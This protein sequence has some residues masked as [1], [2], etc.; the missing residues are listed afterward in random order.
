[1]RE[2]DLEKLESHFNDQHKA[3]FRE[4]YEGVKKYIQYFVQENIKEYPDHKNLIVSSIN[5]N[6][7]EAFLSM[8]CIH[9]AMMPVSD[10][11]FVKAVKYVQEQL[12]L[13]ACKELKRMEA[14]VQREKDENG[15]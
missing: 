12:A 13:G 2:D 8:L 14:D 11:G 6:C 9:V 3:F 10:E 4:L 15:Q 5:N 1:M 7:I